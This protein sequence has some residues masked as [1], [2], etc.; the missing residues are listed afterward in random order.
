MLNPI[1]KFPL[2]QIQIS[3]QATPC[4]KPQDKPFIS[5]PFITTIPITM[6]TTFNLFPSSYTPPS[7]PPP[8]IS[9]PFSMSFLSTH[10]LHALHACNF[11]IAQPSLTKPIQ[12]STYTLPSTRSLC[13]LSH[14]PMCMACI[15]FPAWAKINERHKEAYYE[16]WRN[17][18]NLG[19]IAVG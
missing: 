11:C 2:Y 16:N 1:T 15:H 13:R 12:S 4:L 17:K 9:H 6:P 3:S 18:G 8:L 14:L 19:K 7:R 10:S 5:L